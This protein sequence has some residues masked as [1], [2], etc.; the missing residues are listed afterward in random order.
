MKRAKV[1]YAAGKKAFCFRWQAAG[2]S[3]H[4]QTTVPAAGGSATAA[5]TKLQTRGVG[6]TASWLHRRFLRQ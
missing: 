5:A 1:K 2:Q 4:F 6:S 3:I